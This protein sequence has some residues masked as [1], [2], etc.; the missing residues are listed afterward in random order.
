MFSTYSFDQLKLCAECIK[1]W[2]IQEI[3]SLSVNFNKWI[4]KLFDIILLSKYRM[5]IYL[6]DEVAK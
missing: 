6:R 5:T 1:L 2:I 3:T 4:N